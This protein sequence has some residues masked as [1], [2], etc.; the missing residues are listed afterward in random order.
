[1]LALTHAESLPG[2]SGDLERIFQQNSSRVFGTAY[3]VTGSAQDAEDCLQTVFLRLLR[4]QSSL[5]LSPNPG[6]Y[7]HR[8]AINAALDLMRARSRSR[9]IPLDDL[10]VP[11]ADGEHAGPDRRQQDREMRRSLRQ[12][13]LQLSPKSATIFSMRFLEGTPNRESAEAINRTQAAV[14]V[15]PHRARKQVKEELASFVGGK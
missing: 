1:M 14:N 3:R 8:A 12:A 15:S 9:S 4:R 7:L 11:P 10:E 13:I 6:S 2:P 5:D